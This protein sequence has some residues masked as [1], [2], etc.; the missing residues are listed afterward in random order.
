VRKARCIAAALALYWPGVGRAV[1]PEHVPLLENFA[2]NLSFFSGHATSSFTI[3]AFVNRDLGDWLVVR[4]LASSH[5]AVKI[6]VGR[7]L[8]AAGRHGVATLVGVSRIV[9]Q[10]HYLSDVGVGALVGTA[11]GNAVSA[12]H[13]DGL[14][15]PRRWHVRDVHASAVPFPGGV[16][17]A[18]TF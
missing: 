9:D 18:G 10:A 1:E 12:L 8:P 17:V 4:P 2:H 16:A 11:I 3:A 15:R 7:V 5:P 14:G 6:V 13:F